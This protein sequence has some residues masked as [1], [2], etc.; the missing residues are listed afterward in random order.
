MLLRKTEAASLDMSHLRPRGTWATFWESKFKGFWH[1][2][3][4]IDVPLYYLVEKSR[5]WAPRVF[6]TAPWLLS[7][8][9]A[10]ARHPELT[11]TFP[12]QE[13]VKNPIEDSCLLLWHF[14]MESGE[15]WEC[16]QPL[17][18]IEKVCQG[19]EWNK[20]WQTCHTP[21]KVICCLFWRTYSWKTSKGLHLDFD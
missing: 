6:Y 12:M 15:K 19:N 1:S 2:I 7:P 21:N 13:L 11:E 4:H 16:F 17:K 14:C 18:N 8:L 20:V 5:D 9:P 10:M 3:K